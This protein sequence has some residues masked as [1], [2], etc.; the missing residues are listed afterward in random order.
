MNPLFYIIGI[1]A[2]PAIELRGAIPV[3]IALGVPPLTAFIV[4]TLA[5]IILILP[6]FYVLD[7]FFDFFRKYAWVDKI[8]TQVQ[9]KTQKYVE[10]YGVIGLLLFVAIPLPGSGAYSG[11]LAAYIFNVNR[12]QSHLSIA[13]GVMVAGIL[14]YLASLGFLT[15]FF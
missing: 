8:I 12:K 10:K 6:I 9:N 5:N 11:C 14:V 2:L 13:G 1:T 15:L 3:G 4:A 7:T